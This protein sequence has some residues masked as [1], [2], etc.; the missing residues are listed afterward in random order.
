MGLCSKNLS[1]EPE[2]GTKF[3]FNY[4][5][6]IPIVSL[7]VSQFNVGD[8]QNILSFP[9]TCFLSIPFQL[10]YLFFLYCRV[11]GAL[12]HKTDFP[13]TS[14]HVFPMNGVN[15]QAGQLSVIVR[16]AICKT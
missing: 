10:R 8:P 16:L 9:G 14:V 1:T 11:L 6:Y 15:K 12:C 13:Q 4:L 2:V 5:N 3:L 7:A